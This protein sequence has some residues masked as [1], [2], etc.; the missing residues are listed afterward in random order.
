MTAIFLITG[1][2]GLI[3]FRILLDALKAGHN[4]RYTV[5]S[6]EKAK[7]VSSNP[8]IKTLGITIGDRLSPVVIADFTAD[9]AFDSALDGVTHIIHA[10]SP[11]PMPFFDP[12]TQV[13]EPTVKMATNLLESSLKSPSVRRVV[14]TSSIVANLTPSSDRSAATASASTRIAPPSPLPKTFDSVMEAYVVGKQVEMRDSDEFVRAR[15][16]HFTVSHVVPGYVFGRNELALD[17]GMMQAHNS[18]NNFLMV[19]LLGGELPFPIHGGFAHVEDVAQVHLRVA[20][21]GAY[22]G[23]DVGIA[24]KV[25][26]GTIFDQIKDKYPEAVK[27]GTFKEGKVPTLPVD[28]DSSDARALLGGLKSFESAVSD[29]AA[30]YLELLE[31]E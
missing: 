28:Y 16:P 11:V 14:I 4:V 25:D 20:L 7:V 17:T 15:G 2:S 12:T 30:Q 8:A 27:A 26:Y 18:S 5:R 29:V 31:K 9:G 22:A 21:E 3:G 19:G 1:A 13:F 10:G 23:K 6:E 24:S